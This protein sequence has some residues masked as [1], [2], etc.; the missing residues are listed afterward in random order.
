[1]GDW[2]TLVLFGVNVT[3]VVCNN[4][5]WGL[6]K[7]PMKFVYGYDVAAD[8]RPETRYDE[9]LKALGGYGEMVTDPTALGPAIERALSF[10][11]PSMVNVI[12][13]PAVA[14]PRSSNLA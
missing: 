3:I 1:M 11:G 8:L 9:V 14:Y 5:I 2:D 12:T 13:D 4:G 6:E 7:H 10:D